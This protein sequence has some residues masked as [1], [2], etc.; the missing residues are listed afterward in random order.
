MKRIVSL[1]LSVTLVGG[2]TRTTGAAPVTTAFTYQGTLDRGGMHEA[3]GCQFQ[4]KLFDAVTG[5]VQIGATLTPTITVYETGNFSATL[6]F[7]AGIFDG[8]A[9]W[10]EIAVMCPGDGSF[11]TLTPRQPLT[12]APYAL[13]ALAAPGGG[14]TLPFSGGATNQGSTSNGIDA[15]VGIGAFGATN[16][17]TTGLSH[18]LIGKT[19]STWHNATGVL[20]VG[21]ATSGFTSGVQ[22]YATASPNGTGVV[23]Q[24]QSRGGW[25][26]SSGT[27]SYAVEGVGVGRGV[28]GSASAGDGVYGS[29]TNAGVYGS[30]TTY[31]IVGSSVNGY[32]VW[33]EYGAGL[34]PPSGTNAGVYG[35]SNSSNAGSAGVRGQGGA[36]YG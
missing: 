12:A 5:G 26:Q 21:L 35:Q 10:V 18:G 29:G 30:G 28:A 23:G 4:F 8:N 31:G 16:T 13:Y 36:G 6:D 34:N 19:T 7:G 15:L 22:G 32:G 17:A 3:S 20:G 27:G 33:G 1:I 11:T 2:A 14:F 9:R 24:G 25:F